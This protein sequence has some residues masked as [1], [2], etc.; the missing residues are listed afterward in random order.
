MIRELNDKESREAMKATIE[1]AT[2][3]AKTLSEADLKLDEKAATGACCLYTYGVSSCTGGL[4]KKSCK[5]A[6][7][8]TGTMWKW[9]KG[10]SCSEISCP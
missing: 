3:E 9:K 10:K 8:N 4:T 5:K 6:A 7:S 2:E 1:R